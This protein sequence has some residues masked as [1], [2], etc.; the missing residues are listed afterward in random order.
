MSLPKE[1]VSTRVSTL[2]AKGFETY[3][4]GLFLIIPFLLQAEVW[5]FAECLWN[6][7]SRKG[8]GSLQVF[9]LLFFAALGKIKNIN[10]LK[11]IQDICLAML[12]VL[13]KALQ[14]QELGRQPSS[15]SGL[16][17]LLADDTID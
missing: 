9:L 14:K 17:Y 11:N 12:A 6:N 7:F 16:I 2:L 13:P 5:R 3:Y 15:K 8:L 10:R 1:K 4:V